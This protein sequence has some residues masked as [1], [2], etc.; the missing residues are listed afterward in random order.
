MRLMSVPEDAHRR[1][2]VVTADG[3]IAIAGPN[4]SEQH[5]VSGRL[6]DLITGGD[7]HLTHTVVY[8]PVQSPPEKPERT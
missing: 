5:A 7:E 6:D 8:T 1:L 3:S 4:A 2:G